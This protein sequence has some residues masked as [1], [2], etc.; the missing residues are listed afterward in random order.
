MVTLLP[1]SPPASKLGLNSYWNKNKKKKNPPC[2]RD[3]QDV[4]FLRAQE[5][6]ELG[7]VCG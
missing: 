6:D 1:V 2:N 5:G 4:H 7:E 3:I